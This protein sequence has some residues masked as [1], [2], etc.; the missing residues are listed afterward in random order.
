MHK[1]G[2]QVD[3]NKSQMSSDEVGDTFKLGIRSLH[4][5]SQAQGKP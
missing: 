4:L 3:Y 2:I 5:G 1:R